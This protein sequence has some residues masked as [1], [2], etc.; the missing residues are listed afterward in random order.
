LYQEFRDQGKPIDVMIMD[1]TIAGGMGGKEAVQK[2]LAIDPEAR[3]I[4]ASG[5]SNDPVMAKYREHG[6][7]AVVVKP[8]S[9]EELASALEAALR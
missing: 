6:F 4:V 5:Y 8:F 9:M 2:V 1:L 7:R 3:A